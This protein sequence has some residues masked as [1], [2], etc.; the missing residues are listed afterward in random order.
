MNSSPVLTF[1]SDTKPAKREALA[2]HWIARDGCHIWLGA[3][4]RDGYGS[5]N[6][7]IKGKRK[8]TSAHRAAWI[9]LRGDIPVDLVVDHLCR[10]R[11]C[12]NPEHLEPVTVAENTRR[13]ALP[14]ENRGKFP[15][16]YPPKKEKGASLPSRR[17]FQCKRGHA[18]SESNTHVYVDKRGYVRCVCRPCLAVNKARRKAL[19]A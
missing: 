18:D 11:S 4:D 13:G 14:L 19:A 10:N 16:A 2:A 8:S 6:F 5:F 15:G 1:Q 17:P 7:R 12:V 3:L 9:L